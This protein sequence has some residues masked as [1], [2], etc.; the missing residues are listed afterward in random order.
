MPCEPSK[1]PHNAGRSPQARH[2]HQS[3]AC[4]D[5]QGFP[6]QEESGDHLSGWLAGGFNVLL[7]VAQEKALPTPRSAEAQGIAP[8]PFTGNRLP[9]L[10]DFTS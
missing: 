9:G 3:P 10:S 8:Y 4:G 2:Y 7:S 5:L 6:Q 1:G